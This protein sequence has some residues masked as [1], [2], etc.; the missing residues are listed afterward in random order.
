[1]KIVFLLL[2]STISFSSFAGE[3]ARPTIYSTPTG[4]LADVPL[5]R[6][7]QE[8]FDALGAPTKNTTLMG[9][10]MWTY[11]VGSG[12]GLKQFTFIFNDKKTLEDVKDIRGQTTVF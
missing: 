10:E 7:Q 6:T 4:Y 8:V 5:N 9:K 11:E 12:Y 2:L 1:M 3:L